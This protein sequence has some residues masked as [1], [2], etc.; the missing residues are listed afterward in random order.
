[1]KLLFRSVSLVLT[2][3]GQTL[4]SLTSSLQGWAPQ[5][6][7]VPVPIP[8]QRERHPRGPAGRLPYRGS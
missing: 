6:A 8:I 4:Q 2:L 7:P 5:R 1:M 3:L